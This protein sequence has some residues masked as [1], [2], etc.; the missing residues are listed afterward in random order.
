MWP[1]RDLQERRLFFEIAVFCACSYR[2]RIYFKVEV[3]VAI[4]KGTVWN[5]YRWKTKLHKNFTEIMTQIRIV[6]SQ[7]SLIIFMV[8]LYKATQC[9][10]CI[11]QLLGGLSIHLSGSL[12]H[13]K[14]VAR[15]R[16]YT[17]LVLGARDG[18]LYV[19]RRVLHWYG[20]PCRTDSY[21]VERNGRRSCPYV[22]H[23]RYTYIRV[24]A[25]TVERTI[26][27]DPYNV[28]SSQMKMSTGIKKLCAG[29][30]RIYCNHCDD[31][32]SRSS[33]YAHRKL[34]TA[35]QRKW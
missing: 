4:Y 13:S 15:V 8:N 6:N 26:D 21:G 22:C 20:F 1:D 34:I 29:S 5:D 14:I 18:Q 10:P 33:F 19:L 23:T 9:L 32:V 7:C 27:G 31:Y 30:S 12:S 3:W 17:S 2:L 16:I 25:S 28:L 11:P 35:A 24:Y